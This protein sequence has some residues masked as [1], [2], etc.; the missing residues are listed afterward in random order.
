MD[1]F[2][3]LISLLGGI[4]VGGKSGLVSGSF[5]TAE[6]QRITGKAGRYFILNSETLLRR[7]VSR[8]ASHT[9]KVVEG[10]TAMWK[11]L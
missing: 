8:T 5:F 9:V 1:K 6:T 10:D 7:S 2:I 11:F 4:N 3:F